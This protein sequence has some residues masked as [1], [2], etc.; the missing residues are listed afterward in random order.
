[1]LEFLAK[2]LPLTLPEGLLTLKWS[3]RVICINN[4]IFYTHPAFDVKNS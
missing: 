4:W 2:P 3:R 1:M